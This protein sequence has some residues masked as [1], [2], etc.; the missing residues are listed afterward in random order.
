VK[1]LRQLLEK[2]TRSHA[3]R[4]GELLDDRY[5]WVPGAAFDIRNIGAVDIRLMCKG[6]LAPPLF[7]SVSADVIA[8]A[9]TDIHVRQE[10]RMSPI[11]LQTISD[12]VVDCTLCSS[13]RYV[14]YNMQSATRTRGGKHGR[15]WHE[16]VQFR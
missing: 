2:L 9:L 12:I 5:R 15:E 7:F 3:K 11:N 16:W 4:S 13:E 10:T 1:L 6:F 8:E 14:T